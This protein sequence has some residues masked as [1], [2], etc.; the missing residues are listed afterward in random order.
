MIIVSFYYLH[1]HL[2]LS[3]PAIKNLLAGTFVSLPY[4]R[5]RILSQGTGV[6]GEGCGNAAGGTMVPH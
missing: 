3:F 2:F 6:G 4:V 5:S 1:E